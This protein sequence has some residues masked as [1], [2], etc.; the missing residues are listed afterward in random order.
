MKNTDKSLQKE[1]SAFGKHIAEARLRAGSTQV[2][3]SKRLSVTQQVV[4][5]CERRNVALRAE[6][7]RTLAETLRTTADYRIG[8][9]ASWKGTK[10]PLGKARQVFEQV[11]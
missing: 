3:L 7:I 9:S 11:S 1:P 2:E 10:G 4:A 8:I 6:Q 5:A